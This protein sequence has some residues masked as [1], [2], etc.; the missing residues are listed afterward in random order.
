MVR[1]ARRRHN[2]NVLGVSCHRLEAHT[3]EMPRSALALRAERE[4]I[5]LCHSGVDDTGFRRLV[6][7]ALR[8]VMTVDAAFVARADPDT[9]LFTGAW[10]EQPLDS[11]T[12]AFLDN[13][14]GDD[15]VNKFATLATSPVPVSSLDV[16]THGERTASARYRDI[17]RPLGLGDELRVALVSETRCWGYLCLHREDGPAGFG[18]G[19]LRTVARLAPHLAHAMRTATV[20]AASTA[21]APSRPGVVLLAPDR[22]LVAMT[23]E[24][25]EALSTLEPDRIRPLPPAVYTVAAALAAAESGAARQPSVRVRTLT[26]TWLYLHASRLDAPDAKG[27]VAVVV[28]PVEPR[29]TVPMLLAAHGLTR[30]ETDVTRLVLRGRPTR[31]IADELCISVH[32]VQDHMKAVFDKVGVHSRR[33]LVGY[34]LSP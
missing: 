23:S 1:S 24:A 2:P 26:G 4:V 3:D 9:L 17:M 27:G 29:D 22:S 32:T 7:P 20:R 21:T 25:E 28:E 10:P 16:A 5:R 8:R 18:T 31:A 14:F 12:P 34:L 6:V 13:E 15:D 30:R 11:V 19:E 33:D